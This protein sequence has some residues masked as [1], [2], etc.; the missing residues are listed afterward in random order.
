MCIGVHLQD[1]I[2]SPEDQTQSVNHNSKDLYHWPIS[3]AQDT[4]FIKVAYEASTAERVEMKIW[5]H[6]VYVCYSN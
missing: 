1:S 2:L 6:G 4:H 5:K 3:L